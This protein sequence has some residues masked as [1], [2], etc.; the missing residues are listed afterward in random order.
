MIAPSKPVGGVI[1]W[2][3]Y[4]PITIRWVNI[5]G[6]EMFPDRVFLR[7]IKNNN[8]LYF[9]GIIPLTII[10]YQFYMNPLLHKMTD[11]FDFYIF[12]SKGNGEAILNRFK[13]QL[14]FKVFVNIN[15]NVFEYEVSDPVINGDIEAW[16]IPNYP[17]FYNHYFFDFGRLV[18]PTDYYIERN[19]NNGTISLIFPSA[20]FSNNVLEF[21]M[22]ENPS[23]SWDDRLVFFKPSPTL[24]RDPWFFTDE[25][26]VYNE[27]LFLTSTLYHE[28]IT[29][30]FDPSFTSFDPSDDERWNVTVNGVDVEYTL[31]GNTF[32][33]FFD[34]INAG[35]VKSILLVHY[36]VDDEEP[37]PEPEPNWFIQLLMAIISFIMTIL[38]LIF[39]G[40]FIA[41]KR[42]K[43]QITI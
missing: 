5:F 18:S 24:T 37:E 4:D 19:F 8:E 35:E 11:F 32:T 13:I 3:K 6:T 41:R 21:E 34:E 31:V 16:I 23:P 14:N 40:L 2:N 28:D 29:L 42:A 25:G 38:S 20:Q 12:S 9:E 10:Y 17:A 26:T 27:E 7:V 22:T 33:I 30:Q 36:Y 39:G 15:L 43:Q 1:T